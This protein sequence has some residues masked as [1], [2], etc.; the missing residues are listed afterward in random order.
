MCL[1]LPNANSADCESIELIKVGCIL[2]YQ[3]LSKIFFMIGRLIKV[4][5]ASVE[6]ASPLLQCPKFRKAQMPSLYAATT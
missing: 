4:T 3:Y 5:G 6:Q 1:Y 2:L